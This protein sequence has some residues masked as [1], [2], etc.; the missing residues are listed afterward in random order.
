MATIENSGFD[1]YRGSSKTIVVLFMILAIVYFIL[2]I[3]RMFKRKGE[4]NMGAS[5][6]HPIVEIILRVLEIDMAP[7]FMTQLMAICLGATFIPAVFMAYACLIPMA[8]IIAGQFMKE[9]AGT[10][11]FAHY[12][13]VGGKAL[14]LVLITL[15]M[16]NI[17]IGDL[18][19]KA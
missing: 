5:L 10:K 3:I 11:K 2:A 19:F 17:W 15:T 12:V 7:F 18:Q 16:T 13:V 8:V 14:N 1:M 9:I 6:F 4:V